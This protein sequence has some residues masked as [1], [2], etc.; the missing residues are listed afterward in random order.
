[1][2]I[3]LGVSGSGVLLGGLYAGGAFT[4]G[5]VYDVPIAQAYSEL[6]TMP[7]PP[8]LAQ[9]TGGSDA[10]KVDTRRLPGSI[11]WHFRVG[12]EEVSLFTARL[13]AEGPR[14]TR[15]RI[16]YEPGKPLSPEIGRLTSTRLMRDLAEITMSEQVD[17]QLEN[18]PFDQSEAMHA[19]AVHITEHPEI[20]QEY[21][22]AVNGMFKEV[23]RQAADAAHGAPS[24]G[25]DVDPPG[26]NH[27]AMEAATR[28]SVVLPV[29]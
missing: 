7:L 28:P 23:N 24:P 1:M 21:G 5:Q 2:K 22:H 8:M 25:Y 17:A 9:A 3:L 10:V 19:M 15:I 11:E 20:M 13:T 4:P 16:S 29:N 6:A 18:R 26:L 27:S 14:R 12:D